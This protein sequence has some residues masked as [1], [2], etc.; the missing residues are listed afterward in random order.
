MKMVA[1]AKL[2]KAQK[3]ITSMRPYAEKFNELVREFG[4][5][6]DS[7]VKSPYTIRRVEKKVLLIPITSNRGLCGAFNTNVAKQVKKLINQEEAA[8]EV[9]LMIIG[10][11]GQ[12]LLSKQAT[13]MGSHPAI[14]DDLS[15]SNSVDIIQPI[16]NLYQEEK[17][18]KVLL[19]YNRFKNVAVQ[20][21]IVEQFLPI[22]PTPSEESQ[23]SNVIYEPSIQHIVQEILPKALKI[24]FYKSLR[25]SLAAEQAARMTAMHIATENAT[26]V[27]DQ[28]KLTYNKARQAAI[29]AEILEIVSGAEALNS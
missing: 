25:D 7:D 11:K 8:K 18:D 9:Q 16:M 28:L 3:E 14:L 12:E 4:N 20:E 29:T 15:Y 2:K 21:L 23:S 27:L 5:S 10:K 6:L 26:E 17:I 24:Q 13:I 22:L 19:L 1:S